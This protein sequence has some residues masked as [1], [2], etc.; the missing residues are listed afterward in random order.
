[1]TKHRGY[2][3]PL[4][5]VAAGCAADGSGEEVGSSASPLIGPVVQLS[6]GRHHSCA[7]DTDGIAWCAGRDLDGQLGNQ[8]AGYRFEPD[9]VLRITGVAQIEA[10]FVHSCARL[11]DGTVWCWGK[12]AQ[13]QLGDGSQTTRSLPKRV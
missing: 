10:G 2:L 12:N 7:L 5:A 6:G 3:A 9:Q 11:D 13:G 4:L 1:M 8:G